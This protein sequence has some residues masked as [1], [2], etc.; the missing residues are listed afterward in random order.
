MR[1]LVLLLVGV[2][3]RE[4]VDGGEGGDPDVE[5]PG[6]QPDV[7]IQPAQQPWDHVVGEVQDLWLTVD[8]CFRLTLFWNMNLCFGRPDTVNVSDVIQNVSVVI[9]SRSSDFPLQSLRE[10]PAN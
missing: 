7:Q 8:W 1:L 10:N 5:A 4:D 6:Q 3:A 9:C 2:D